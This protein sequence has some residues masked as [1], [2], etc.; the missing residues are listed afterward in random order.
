MHTSLPIQA[1]PAS[2]GSTTLIMAWVGASSTWLK[3][4]GWSH[5]TIKPAVI[6]LPADTGS[7][8]TVP[9]LMLLG[10]QVMMM[11]QS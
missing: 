9:L 1:C 2:C 7:I 5:L 8:L 6:I 11:V 3:S 4:G 10:H